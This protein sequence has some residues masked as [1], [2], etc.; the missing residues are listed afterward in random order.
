MIKLYLNLLILFQFKCN[1]GGTL[2][3]LFFQKVNEKI[4]IA[5]F[6]K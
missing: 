4:A 5:K 3:V 1:L 6:E 2:K